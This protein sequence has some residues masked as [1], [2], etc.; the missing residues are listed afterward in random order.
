MAARYQPYGGSV[1]PQDTTRR[2]RRGRRRT[3]AGVVAML[4]ILA[5]LLA[6]CSSSKKST[7]GTA[8]TSAAGG[9]SSSDAGLAAAQALV[10]KYS[11][12]PTQIPASTPIGK[13]IPKGKT[14]VFV[15]CGTPNCS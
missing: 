14:V 15:S 9:S 12:Q 5:L 2:P 4:S 1:N 3:A 13:P 11:Q 7:A 10:A 6:A 8:G